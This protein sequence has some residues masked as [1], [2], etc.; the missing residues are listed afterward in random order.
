MTVTPHQPIFFIS[1]PQPPY[2][3]KKFVSVTQQTLRNCPLRE[4]VTA[5]L[6]LDLVYPVQLRHTTI[7]WYN[8]SAIVTIRTPFYHHSSPAGAIVPSRSPKK[9]RRQVRNKQTRSSPTCIFPLALKLSPCLPAT[10]ATV[11]RNC[12]IVPATWKTCEQ[13][14]RIDACRHSSCHLRRQSTFAPGWFS[15]TTNA[16]R[17]V[18]IRRHCKK[19]TITSTV[20]SIGVASVSFDAPLQCRAPPLILFFTIPLPAYMAHVNW[21]RDKYHD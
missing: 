18:D 19:P 7:V 14:I 3:S 10:H 5:I 16:V 8:P 20:R 15:E 12:L 21:G 11:T 1:L 2:P 6:P 17:Y 13:G 9:P 4:G